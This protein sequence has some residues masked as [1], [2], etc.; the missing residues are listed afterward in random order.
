MAD[1]RSLMAEAEK[2]REEEALKLAAEL[3]EARRYELQVLELEEKAIAEEERARLEKEQA[4]FLKREADRAALEHAAYLMDEERRIRAE[5]ALLEATSKKRQLEE[6]NV[7]PS[8]TK[9][10]PPDDASDEI[11]RQTLAAEAE[12]RA[13]WLREVEA[14]RRDLEETK[15]RR[16][17]A[18][19]LRK[20]TSTMSIAE[21]SA[22][23]SPNA[24]TPRRDLIE[25]LR[26]PQKAS[27]RKDA[28]SAQRSPRHVN[29]PKSP[30]TS[31]DSGKVILIMTVDIG[32]GRVA[33]IEIKERSNYY[34]LAREFCANHDLPNEVIGPLASRIKQNV[35]D[36]KQQQ[37]Q[38]KQRP[39][40]ANPNPNSNPKSGRRSNK[41]RVEALVHDV[42]LEREKKRKQAQLAQSSGSYSPTILD[43]S[44]KLVKEGSGDSVFDRLYQSKPSQPKLI[45]SEKETAEAET[46]TPNKPKSKAFVNRKSRELTASRNSD[47]F[48]NYGERLYQEGLQSIKSRNA[49]ISEMTS[50]DQEDPELTLKPKTSKTCRTITRDGSEAWERII[51]ADGQ[52]K[53]QGLEMLQQ[54]AIEDVEKS[55]TFKPSIN[56]RS[57]KLVLKLQQGRNISPN[58]HAEQLYLDATRRNERLKE[59]QRWVPE[60]VTF[61]PTTV[62]KRHNE[63]HEDLVNRLVNSKRI[64]DDH[65][66]E[67]RRQIHS[68]IDPATGQPLFTPITGRSPKK[69]RTDLPIGDW[70]FMNKT[71]MDDIKSRL[72]QMDD[73]IVRNQSTI[74]HVHPNSAKI[75]NELRARRLREVFDMIDTDKDG[76]IQS[77]LIDSTATDLPDDICFEL[78]PL[79]KS[80]K[81]ELITFADFVCLMDEQLSSNKWGPRSYLLTTK[82]PSTS[83]VQQ[84]EDEQYSFTPNLNPKS[85]ELATKKRPSTMP[86]EQALLEEAKKKQERIVEQLKVKEEEE[87]ASCTFT[88]NTL[89]KMPEVEYEACEPVESRRIDCDDDWKEQLSSMLG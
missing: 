37:T 52:L 46:A 13:R 35:A 58:Q 59:Y 54:K 50:K 29:S 63:S 41:K 44:R 4:D 83:P 60:E 26:S 43:R 11:K 12:E 16:N 87:L 8:P 9:S 6:S 81:K 3:A 73:E 21:S 89:M 42:P 2:A 1:L 64:T 15:R 86:V 39:S 36:L 38:P 5:A 33:S 57:E 30:R 32:D 70:L 51:D 45:E 49:K 10:S 88:P 28:S 17:E 62:S 74:S 47:G 48:Q 76:V 20:L 75:V 19:A 23:E 72:A 85:V 65:L 34:E 80:C 25:T 18:S 24:G 22:I 68:N 69:R 40:S 7:A 71:D 84:F 78:F 61:K 31:R 14:R 77:N 67:L 56:K 66:E 79:I 82:K 27:P 55:C 53:R